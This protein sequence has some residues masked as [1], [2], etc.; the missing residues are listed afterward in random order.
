MEYHRALINDIYTELSLCKIILY[1]DDTVIYYSNKNAST[2]ESTLNEEVNRIA[3]WMSSNHLTL[4]LKKGKTEFILYG[5]SKK[6]N[7]ETHNINISGEKVNETTQYKYLGIILD[8]HLNLHEYLATVYKKASS[9]LK[10]LKRVRSNLTSEIAG[11]YISQHDPTNSHLL[12]NSF[13]GT[14]NLPES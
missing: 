2:V 7:K 11:K 8:Q 14:S 4:N 5:T 1:A 12:S 6:L 13:L 10:L 9:R 3:S